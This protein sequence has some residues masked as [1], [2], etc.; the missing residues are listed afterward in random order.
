[1]KLPN[2]VHSDVLKTMIDELNEEINT[3]N[4][5]VVKVDETDKDPMYD[6]P[7]EDDDKFELNYTK[8]IEKLIRTSIEYKRYIGIL[9]NDFDMTKC[10]VLDKVDIKDIKRVGFEFHHYPATL[11]DIV[12]AVRETF[13]EDPQRSALSPY[14]S[15]EIANHVMKLHYEGKIGLVPLTKTAHELVH[16]GSIFIPLNKDYVFGDYKKLIE[17]YNFSSD[18]MNTYNN[19]KK[20]SENESKVKTNKFD[21][22]SIK[23][24]MEEAKSPN[25]ISV[26]NANSEK[27]INV[28]E[29]LA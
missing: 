16:S 6:I 1:M 3:E 17:E 12:V 25:M 10:K 9:K 26:E 18:F 7:E 5:I 23:V 22:R 20:L 24:E 13:R 8:Y 29:L 14:K 27:N 28:E 11:F 15:F 4:E 19:V 2:N 21:Y